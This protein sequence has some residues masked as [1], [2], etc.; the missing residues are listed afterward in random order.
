M[1]I[2]F[3][4]LRRIQ[5]STR[6]R[7]VLCAVFSLVIITMI[8]ALVRAIVTTVGVKRQ[9]DPLWM[10]LWTSIELNVGTDIAETSNAKS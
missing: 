1:S 5:I 8:F 10:Y 3:L 7:V 9:I 4:V 2:P 6:E